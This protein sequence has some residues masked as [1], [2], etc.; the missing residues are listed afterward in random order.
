MSE[1][2]KAKA[3]DVE[4]QTKLSSKEM[5]KH[6]IHL[7]PER[8]IGRRDK[9]NE[10]FRKHYEYDKEEVRFIAEHREIVGEDIEIWTGKYAG[11]PCEFWRVPTN[12]PVW[13]PRYLADQIKRCAY[14]KYVMKDHVVEKSSIGSIYGSMAIETKIQRLDAYPARE[15]STI[16][17]GAS[18]F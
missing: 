12:K 5:N 14:N 8:I 17:M 3:E 13:G 2:K 7:K 11:V 4:P 9:F 10:A 18:G 15:T 6:E 1:I 16:F